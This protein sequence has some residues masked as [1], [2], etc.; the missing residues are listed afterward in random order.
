[1]D[2]KASKIFIKAPNL[3]RTVKKAI[4]MKNSPDF[5]KSGRGRFIK[6][7]I[8]KK[9]IFIFAKTLNFSLQYGLL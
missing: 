9:I 7:E 2:K 8:L 1:L 4:K 6:L 3:E 5:N